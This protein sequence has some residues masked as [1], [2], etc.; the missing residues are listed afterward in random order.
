MESFRY[1]C[2]HLFTREQA[3]WFR[4]WV[5]LHFAF[6]HP[7]PLAPTARVE[8]ER[9]DFFNSVARGVAIGRE[10]LQPGEPIAGFRMPNGN[11]RNGLVRLKPLHKTVDRG[12]S[13]LP[14]PLGECPLPE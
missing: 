3:Q 13:A 8:V 7:S 14:E 10:D 11:A 4:C 1:I 6:T 5:R 9:F 2:L 12:D